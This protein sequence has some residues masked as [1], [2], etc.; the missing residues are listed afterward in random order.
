MSP[1]SSPSRD[2]VS[3][4]PAVPPAAFDQ[5]A[6]R[7]T[8]RVDEVRVDVGT[9][10]REAIAEHVVDDYAERLGEGVRFPPVVVFR[11]GSRYCLA[12]GFHRLQAFRRA[13]RDEIEADVYVGTR[14]DALWFAL[15]ANRKH[16][17]RLNLADKR[18]A[19]ELAL[20]TWPDLS[21]RR[22]AA[23]VGCSQPYVHKVRGQVITSYHLPGRVVGEDGKLHP[24]SRRPSDRP[25]SPEI[26]PDEPGPEPPSDSD[27]GSVPDPAVSSVPG[28]E[29][30]GGSGQA[31]SEPAVDGQSSAGA[32]VSRPSGRQPSQRAQD[33]SN[34]IVSVVT[35]D[36][37][38]LL[39]QEDLIE[40]AALDRSMLS[41]WIADLERARTDL[42]RLIR[43][44]REEA[45]NGEGE[46]AG[47]GDDSSDPD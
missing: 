1:A 42:G 40:F 25:V 23:Q 6:E 37:Q 31:S 9:Q 45:V 36:A 34:R 12:D 8:L 32:T 24:A 20:A 35:F 5:V 4:S 10:V 7:R 43:R 38:N 22:I 46:P 3:V 47:E 17:Q 28:S 14:A 11:D 39:A 30:A 18:H 41:V 13:G 2:L 33:R 15:G 21:Q 19:I 16:G 44:L 26:N 27:G 29:V